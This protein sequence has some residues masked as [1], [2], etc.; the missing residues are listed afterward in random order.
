MPVSVCLHRTMH[1]G[2]L[3]GVNSDRDNIPSLLNHL[4]PAGHCACQSTLDFKCDTCLY[5]SAVATTSHHETGRY[6]PVYDAQNL[7]LSDSQCQLFFPGL[8]EDITRAHNIWDSRGDIV[9]EDL[10]AIELVE[11]MAL[12]VIVNGQL[13]V[14][15]ARA[16][17]GDHCRKILVILSSIY[18][19][20]VTNPIQS[21]PPTEFIFSVED[22]LDGVAGPGHSLWILARKANEE[23]VW[24][25]PDFGF[26]SWN[27]DHTDSPIGP[28][29]LVVGRI[30][31]Q[32]EKEAPWN[33]K[34]S[35]LLW[36]G[37][38][39]FAAKMRRGLLEAAK[40][41]PWGDVKE[42]DW[43]RKDDFMAMM[44]HCRYRLI[45][46][47]EERDFLDLP[48]KVQTLLEDPALAERTNNS[49]ATFRDHYLTPAAEACYWRSLRGGW[50]SVS[51]NVGYSLIGYALARFK[52]PLGQDYFR[53]I[54]NE[55]ISLAKEIAA[56][57]VSQEDSSGVLDMNDWATITLDMFG[58]AGLGQDFKTQA[59]SG[60]AIEEILLGFDAGEQTTG[61]EIVAATF[62]W[63][64]YL[65]ATNPHIQ[66]RL[67]PEIRS[68]ISPEL[69][70]TKGPELANRQETLPLLNAYAT[71]TSAYN[72]LSLSPHELQHR[73]SRSSTSP[74]LWGPTAEQFIPDRWI[75]QTTGKID[76]GGAE[77]IYCSL[78]FLHDR[79]DVWDRDMPQQN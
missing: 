59:K 36:R 45:A 38:L 27:N 9:I 40:N 67:Q 8:F 61:Y 58:I 22:R 43:G 51:S 26:W 14:R 39:S 68:Y 23:S 2:T 11:G 53:F 62:S 77:S 57:L 20:L 32:E 60:H 44:D 1:L 64:I 74:H 18:K 75:D 28:Y 5:C 76:E 24:L 70:A 4:I 71:K 78:A 35:K 7:S 19:A 6:N 49:V 72:C 3:I 48:D 25:M 17:N 54:E 69:W 52:Q 34:K 73:I 50:T 31:R 56:E 65:L 63:T 10:E 46:D 12:A 21:R 42:L 41:Q 16:R 66:S 29:S 37:K 47:V 30:R 15:A 55:N 79:I 13:Y 33:E